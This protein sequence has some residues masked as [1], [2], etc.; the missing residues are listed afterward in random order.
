M[1]QQ[2][3]I[4]HYIVPVSLSDADGRP[5]NGVVMIDLDA[6][7]SLMALRRAARIAPAIPAAEEVTH[8]VDIPAPAP[9]AVPQTGR[10]RCGKG[11]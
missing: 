11:G 7:E 1:A 6:L 5:V 10:G 3:P 2:P 4:G 9:A 8:A